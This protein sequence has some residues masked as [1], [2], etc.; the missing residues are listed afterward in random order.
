M[1]HHRD[2]KTEGSGEKAAPRPNPAHVN[3]WVALNKARLSLMRDVDK[4]LRQKGLP[5]LT[6]YDVLWSIEMRGG[7]ARPTEIR[8][9][10]LF[11]PSALSHMTKRMEAAG[12]VKTCVAE[13]DKRGRVLRLT[14]VGRSARLEIWQ[15]Y[16]AALETRLNPLAQI[17]DPEGV[18]EA[19]SRVA[20][21][22]SD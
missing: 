2:V 20:G 4:V 3:I 19:L 7:A 13:E 21:M 12:L 14:Q 15:I 18:A 11:E 22:P 16:G 9:D 10:L 5:P 17:A 1:D 8:G 6:W